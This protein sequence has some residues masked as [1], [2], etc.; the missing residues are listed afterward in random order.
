MKQ[1]VL[2]RHAK[3]VQYD[4]E[5]D[6]S[7][8][9]TPRGLEDAVKVSLHLREQGIVP[10]L[11]ISSPAVRALQTA[12]IFAGTFSYPLKKIRKEHDLY[13]GYTTGDFLKLLR[14]T[15]D[16]E[17]VV[18]VFGHN[19]NFENYAWNICRSFSGELPTCSAVVIDLPIERWAQLEARTGTLVMQVNPKSLP[20]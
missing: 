9:L 10:R 17:D 16:E 20:R 14:T 4:Y 6:F 13:H 19:P 15:P 12:E 8:E 1:L 11:I 3:A 2:V 18:Y 5:N 7:R